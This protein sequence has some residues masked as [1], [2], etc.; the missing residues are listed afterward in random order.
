VRS[1][2]VAWS[3]MMYRSSLAE[4]HTQY[5]MM[6]PVSSG[7]QT[8]VRP[9]HRDHTAA[10]GGSQQRDS[11]CSRLWGICRGVLAFRI[12][13][14]LERRADAQGPG[15]GSLFQ[16]SVPAKHLNDRVRV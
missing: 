16:D 1:Q 13:G 7:W 15:F 11:V 10:I 9:W 12:L 8:S 4:R 5:P 14:H 3:D 2:V 6:T